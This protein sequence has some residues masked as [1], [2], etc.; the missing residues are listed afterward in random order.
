MPECF[1]VAINV[2]NVR[3]DWITLVW[4][5]RTATVVAVR[6]RLAEGFLLRPGTSPAGGCIDGY[7]RLFFAR[8]E[9]GSVVF[10]H[11]GGTGVDRA[12]M[13]RMDDAGQLGP[14]D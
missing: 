7:Y 8:L 2:F 10:V 9:A 13:V 3:Q 14:M 11:H 4:S 5:E 12:Q 1:R 6:D